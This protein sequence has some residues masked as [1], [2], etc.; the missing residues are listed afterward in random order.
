MA[1]AITKHAGARHV[2]VTDVNSYRLEL[3]K[4]VG[5][6]LALDVRSES[7][8]DAQKKLGMKEGFDVGLEMSGNPEAFRSMLTNM[9]HGAKI[10]V[11]GLIPQDTV[12]DWNVV[13]FN[14]LTIKGI[15]GREMYETWYK[16]TVMIQSGLDITPIITHHFHYTEF[17]KGF[18]VMGSG[19]SGKVILNWF[20]D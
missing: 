18:E 13:I 3:A 4:K 7:I 9:C 1:V 10:A 6:T 14:S 8:E 17:E 12:I 5:A 2:V 15:Y 20:D 11:L 19:H 16:M